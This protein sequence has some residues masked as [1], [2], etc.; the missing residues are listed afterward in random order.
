MLRLGEVD[1]LKVSLGDQ[2]GGF[3]MRVIWQFYQIKIANLINQDD[4]V[5]YEHYHYSGLPHVSWF[6]FA[7]AITNVAVEQGVITQVNLA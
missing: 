4:V 2:F 5:E 6:E 7:E 3:H 1:T